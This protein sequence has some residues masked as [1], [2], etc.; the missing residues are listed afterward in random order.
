MTNNLQQLKEIEIEMER[1]ADK[2]SKRSKT[3]S[4]IRNEEPCSVCGKK[5]FVQKYRN[6]V[7]EISGRNVVGE[8]SG[9]MQGYFSLFGG[10]ISGSIDGYTKTL[11]VLS[12]R[13]CGNEREIEVYKYYYGKDEFWDF[14]HNFYF[15]VEWDKIRKIDNF[16]LQRPVGTYLYAKDNRN[17]G[18]SYYN[19]LTE[20]RTDVWA[21]VGF[22]IPKKQVRH[23]IFWKKERYMTWEEL[24]KL[25]K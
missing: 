2:K 19:E 4:K 8:I 21:K 22:N 24:L 12:C 20:W 23:W 25:N 18:Y 14:M 11:P 16:F 17:F 5:E 3:N 13:N 9:S 10:S 1:I 7:G 15:S 6:V